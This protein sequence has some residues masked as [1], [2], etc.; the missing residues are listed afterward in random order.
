MSNIIQLKHAAKIYG[1]ENIIAEVVT[2]TP[3]EATAWLRCNERNRPV[4]KG[5]V[6]FLA[7]EI[8]EGHWQINGQAIVIADNEQVLDG[9]HRLLAIIEAGQPIKTLV[10]YGITPEAFSTIDTG[11]VRSSADALYLHFN[12]YGIG[13]VK[14]VATAVPWVKQLERGALRS[15][16]SNKISNSEVIVY[17][18]DHPSLFQRAERLQSYPKDNRPLSLGVGTALYEYFA[19]KDEEKADKFF[20]DLFTGESLERT[21]VEFVLRAAFQ[22]D[23]QRITSKLPVGVKVRMTIKAWNWRRRG[24]DVATYQTIT[25]SPSE[26]A[27]LFII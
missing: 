23:A 6:N 3:A 2:I 24:M 8:K 13:I 7:K 15:G 1:C 18:Q 22:K 4:R 25:V 5:H 17:A 10:V 12:E 27:R 11:A 19:R 9:Q 20:Q 26:D 21:D 14:A 16:G